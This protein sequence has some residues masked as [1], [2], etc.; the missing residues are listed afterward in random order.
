MADD[1]GHDPDPTVEDGMTAEESVVRE[2]WER[3]W[4]E[5]D[6]DALEELVADQVVRHTAEGTETLTRLELRR[7]LAGAFEAVSASEV[8]IDALVAEGDAVWVRLTLRGVSL[9][10]AAPMSFA[11]LAQY[12]TAGRAHRRVVGSAPARRGLVGLDGRA[13]GANYRAI[14]QGVERGR[15]PSG[16]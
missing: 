12:R 3:I 16:P 13:K 1:D 10:T 11:W 14:F 2:Y 9:P 4:L 6:L 8:S 7:R 5:R 15:G